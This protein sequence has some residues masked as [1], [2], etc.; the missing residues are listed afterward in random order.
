MSDEVVPAGD[1][2]VV[3][4]DGGQP[5]NLTAAK[6]P[7]ASWLAWLPSSH[8]LL[9]AAYI[10]GASGIATVNPDIAFLSPESSRRARTHMTGE[11]GIRYWEFIP[12]RATSSRSLSI[13]ATS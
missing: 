1:I 2:F 6:A 9:F 5:R 12:A 11:L 13:G 7:P 3:P 10:D 8:Q 4:A